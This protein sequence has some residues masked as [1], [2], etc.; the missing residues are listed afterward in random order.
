VKDQSHVSEGT[1]TKSSWINNDYVSVPG[2]VYET[3]QHASVSALA[4]YFYYNR[5]VMT[6]SFLLATPAT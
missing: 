3:S 4:F 1:L 2:L 5:G 6:V